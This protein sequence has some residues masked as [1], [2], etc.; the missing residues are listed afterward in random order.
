MNSIKEWIIGILAAVGAF[1]LA[2]VGVQRGKINKQ[3]LDAEKL[4]REET[5]AR[6]HEL[7]RQAAA[8]AK[9]QEEARARRKAAHDAIVQG[10]RDHFEKGDI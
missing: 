5:Q 10:K 6:L 9:A 3:Q 8:K 7:E 1:L 2:L 4:A